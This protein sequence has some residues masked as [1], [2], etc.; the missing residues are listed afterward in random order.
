[1]TSASF[2]FVNYPMHSAKR[3]VALHDGW[4]QA[5]C[6]D[7]LRLNDEKSGVWLI[8]LQRNLRYQLTDFGLDGKAS[9]DRDDLKRFILGRYGLLIE[10]L[11]YAAFMRDYGVASPNVYELGAQDKIRA[12]MEA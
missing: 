10:E 9:P 5:E 12:L 11:L 7:H 1:M 8:P 4:A 6:L 2:T 3:R